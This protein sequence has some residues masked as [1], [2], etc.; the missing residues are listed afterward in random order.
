MYSDLQLK[1]C[2]Q[3]WT[4]IFS[5]PIWSFFIIIIISKIMFLHVFMSEATL[6]INAIILT[7]S[8]VFN[9]P[10]YCIFGS[11]THSPLRHLTGRFSLIFFQIFYFSVHQSNKHSDACRD[12]M[13][14]NFRNSL[15]LLFCLLVK[16]I[17]SLIRRGIHPAD[18]SNSPLSMLRRKSAQP[19]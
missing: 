13:H 3:L 18:G 5:F 2:K 17:Y 12:I 10:V 9:F 14:L 4:F 16:H 7:C 8:F 1:M 19:L 6:E 11:I 15:N